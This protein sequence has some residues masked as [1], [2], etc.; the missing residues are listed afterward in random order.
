MRE[1][2][3]DIDDP[4][5]ESNMYDFHTFMKYDGKLF[6]GTILY[7]DT[8]SY[9]QYQNGNV[10]G[11]SI[12][13]YLNGQVEEDCTYIDGNYIS[14]KQWY[15]NGQLRYDSENNYVISDEDGILTQKNGNWFYKN[16]N[17]RLTI[18]E[19]VTKLFSSTGNLAILIKQSDLLN[20]YSTSKIIYYH[21]ILKEK[22]KDLQEHIYIYPEDNFN[23]RSIVFVSLNSWIIELYRTN[24]EKEALY[25]IN[26][27]INDSEIRLKE[28][29]NFRVKDI[30]ENFIHN[31]KIFIKQLK[32]GEFNYNN[33]SNVNNH[34]S[35][36]IFD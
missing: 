11:R 15:E 31:S 4:K 2:I 36:I 16:G 18:N 21:K 26:N 8:K 25:I 14:G 12:S 34:Q 33:L 5:I 35:K 10:D 28:D 19:K 9:V 29:V 23:F 32:R 13:Y 1:P 17:E 7:E 20:N 3:I 27:M 6:T 22:Y 24:H 30:E